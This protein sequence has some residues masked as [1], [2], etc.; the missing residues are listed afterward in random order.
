M[1]VAPPRVSLLEE[2]RRPNLARER[3]RRHSRILLH[4]AFGAGRVGYSRPSVWR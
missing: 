3:A 2:K 1:P 4:E